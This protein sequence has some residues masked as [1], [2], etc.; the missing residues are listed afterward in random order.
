MRLINWT[1][2]LLIALS[3][4]AQTDED[5]RLGSGSGTGYTA[6]EGVVVNY[7]YNNFG[8]FYLTVEN[9]A[10]RW[11]GFHGYFFG[12]SSAAPVQISEVAPDVFFYSWRTRGNGSDNVVHNYKTMRVAAH[13]Q[14]DDGGGDAIQMIH[15]VIHCRNTPTCIAPR[16]ELTP[17]DQVGPGIARNVSEFGFPALFDPQVNNVPHAAADLA[18]RTEL[19]GQAIVYETPEGTVRVE[20]TD[21]ETRVTRDGAVQSYQTYATRVSDDLYFISWMGGIG[22]SHI[23]VNKRTGKV[24]NHI[25]PDGTRR[26]SIFELT[27]FDVKENC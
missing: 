21:D 26:E 7:T 6:V 5:T 11:E 25:L 9:G 3:A 2:F 8:G 17:P 18:A 16:S 14:P 15:G 13:L 1:I 20:I 4:H 10:I 27:C 22:G 23:V 12:L 19:S 24:F